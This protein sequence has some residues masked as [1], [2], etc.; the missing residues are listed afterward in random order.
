MNKS[1]ALVL[2][3]CIYSIASDVVVDEDTGLMWQDSADVS[4]VKKDWDN[5]MGYYCT[6]LELGGYDDWRL[7][8]IDELMSIVDKSRY[9]PAIKKI[10]NN[11]KNTWYYSSSDYE[12]D[13][14]RAW[15]AHFRSGGDGYGDKSAMR[16][17]RC[18]RLGK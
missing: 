17:V 14:S 12:G 7:P 10:F 8:S 3:M 5:A 11:T 13:S 18:V 2:I 6:G 16:Y 1:I 15:L 9:E 4:V